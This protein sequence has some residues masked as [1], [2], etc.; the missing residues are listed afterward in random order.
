[1]AV[2]L[3]Q[4]F[5]IFFIEDGAGAREAHEFADVSDVG[6]GICLCLPS[7]TEVPFSWCERK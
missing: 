3:D 2:A 1:M 6:A 4:L 5:E 7:L